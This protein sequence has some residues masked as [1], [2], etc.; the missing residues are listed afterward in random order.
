MALQDNIFVVRKNGGV[1]AMTKQK[2]L[3]MS[4]QP[5]WVKDP[6][7]FLAW[8]LQ[9]FCRSEVRAMSKV[10]TEKAG[11][12]N[13]YVWHWH[14]THVPQSPLVSEGRETC[15]VDLN[16]MQL[17]SGHSE[18]DR[19]RLGVPEPA[20][21]QGQVHAQPLSHGG[22]AQAGFLG[23]VALKIAKE[24][25]AQELSAEDGEGWQPP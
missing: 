11:R 24:Q 21:G 10:W 20:L 14:E 25:D 9:L 17:L 6:W 13:F 3:K 18:P 2:G 16:Q 15:G 4:H 12:A 22:A 1:G 8:S 23:Q 19:I 7:E 5:V